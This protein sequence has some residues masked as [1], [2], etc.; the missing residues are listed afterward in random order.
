MN[1]AINMA[2]RDLKI[3]V[4]C[5][6]GIATST[7]AAEE[8]K[9]VCEDIGIRGYKIIKCSMTEI[10]SYV[11]EVDI[12]LTTNNYKG[13]DK[14]PNMSIMGFI[15]GINEDQLREE[16]GKELQRIIELI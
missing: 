14:T 1:E 13:A 10:P 9:S 7:L 16:L 5:G 12:I 4:A 3:V 8:V 15:S 6:S 11:G 2:K